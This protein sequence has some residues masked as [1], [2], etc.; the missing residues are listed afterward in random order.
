[1]M[2]APRPTPSPLVGHRAL[3]RAGAIRARLRDPAEFAKHY[4][5]LTLPAHQTRWGALGLT[6]RRLLLLA[7]VRHGKS[8]LMAYVLPLMMIAADRNIRI[9]IASKTARLALDT[10]R[11]IGDQLR[12][13]PAL[14]RDFGPFFAPDQKWTDSQ[15]QVIRSDLNQ[16]DPTL[17][18]VGVGGMLEGV[19]GNVAILDDVVDVEGASSEIERAR[20]LEWFNGTLLGRLEP[21][22]RAVII[23]TPWHELDLYG[24]LSTREDYRVER[25]PAILDE[26][27]GLTLWPARFPLAD[28]LRLRKDMGSRAFAAK[29]QAN[30]MP[31]EGA[32]FKA[33]WFR[34]VDPR[35]V[36]TEGTYAIGVDP[37]LGEA[38]S[39]GADWF[40]SCCVMQAVDGKV[41]V[42]AVTADRD[43]P[44][45]SC[46]ASL[47][48]LWE[49]YRPQRIMVEEVGFQWQAVSSAPELR[50]LPLVPQSTEGRDKLAR[51]RGT[52]EAAVE[53]GRLLFVRGGPGVAALVDEMMALPEGAHDDRTDAL[54][55][56]AR[57]F[58]SANA[59]MVVLDASGFFGKAR[60]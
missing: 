22:G 8:L 17:T 21:G 19:G 43:C 38:A 44:L 1:M 60:A 5:G 18:A 2:A 49:R 9:I 15:V 50:G 57:Q 42:M 33:G 34:W 36:P 48:S 29:Y 46:Y 53:G 6:E 14:V 20:T 31:S 30:P 3:R 55:I 58:L 25:T 10:V 52:L 27:A 45:T 24:A 16:R 26:P 12:N 28:L 40:A 54:E 13:N 35:D 56:A 41:Y 11:H 23:G 51:I 7:P 59:G 4:L 37:A 39:K 47:R 32:I